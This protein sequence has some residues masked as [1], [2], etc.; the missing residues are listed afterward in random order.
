MAQSPYDSLGAPPQALPAPRRGLPDALDNTVIDA[1]V[2]GALEE[3]LGPGDVTTLGVVPEEAQAEGVLLAKGEGVLAGLGV[4]ARVFELLDPSVSVSLDLADGDRVEAGL[5]VG[6]VKG[7]ARS[8]LVG[9]RTALNLLQRL[10][11]IAAVT[12]EYVERIAHVPGAR[13]LDTRK[14]TPGLRALQK[15]AVR[16]GGGENHRFGLFDEAMVKDNHVEL[17]G[18]ELEGAVRDLRASL[19]EGVRVTCE[20]R[21][22]AEAQAAVR[23]GAHVVMLDNMTP[24]KIA[25]LL[26]GLRKLA[27]ECAASVEFEASGGITLENVAA[28]A[29][30]GVERISIGALTHSAP[31][32]DLSLKLRPVR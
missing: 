1:V 11:G 5:V 14:T 12:A 23:A 19:G 17:A 22:E 32:L 13:I 7:P 16:C 27:I 8:L 30:A 15:Y 6:R 28:Y 31:S 21:D 29:E 25:G 10:S 2:R 26:P 3:D 24:A 18:R 9:E 20:A 4:F